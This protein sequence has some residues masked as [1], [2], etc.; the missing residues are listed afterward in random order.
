[1]ILSPIT[2]DKE[3][4]NLISEFESLPPGKQSAAYWSN[5]SL[6]DLRSRI[7]T[8]YIEAQKTRCC[9]CNK[10]ISSGNHRLWDIEHVVSR[11]KHARFMFEPMNLA[12]SC[13]DCNINKDRHESLVNPKRKTY[14]KKSEAFTII[15]PHFDSFEDHIFNSSMV[16][17][18]K[19]A[20]GSSTIYA[21]NL[22]RFAE[23]YIDWSGSAV[24]T[25]F[26]EDV[27]LVLE[28]NT[29]TSKAAVSK[30]ITRLSTK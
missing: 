1:M 30:I 21:C 28:E 27:S 3:E 2:Y 26:E 15:H 16:Y 29:S 18:P 25:S 12:A 22:L 9:Y 17:L 19:S 13:P 24:D 20:K 14:P 7:K 5:D 10:H 23:K 11:A 4:E 6:K 8:Y